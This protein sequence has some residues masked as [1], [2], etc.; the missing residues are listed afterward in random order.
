MS[1][2][3]MLLVGAA[4]VVAIWP[5]LKGVF[6]DAAMAAWRLFVRAKHDAAVAPP[7]AVAGD[8]P[9]FQPAIANLA[10][11]RM[12]LAQTELLDDATRK[13]ID[14]LTLALVAGSDK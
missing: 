4:A 8:R 2:E 11:V 1:V 14:T 10:L 5:G 12:R 7:P 13:A 9:G 6:G 3:Q